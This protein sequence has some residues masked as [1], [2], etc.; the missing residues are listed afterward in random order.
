ML[1]ISVL[2]EN[3]DATRVSDK[4]NE[5]ANSNYSL[6]VS[7]S[8]RDRSTETLILA[9]SFE[10]TSQPPAARFRVSGSATLKGNKEEIKDAITPPE[11]NKPPQ[12]LVVLYERVYST[13]YV[14]S[15]ALRAPHPLPNLLKKSS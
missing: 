6:N 5:N 1:D 12:V 7:L 15:T 3:I 8:E 4:V 2:L 11:D 13:L 10:L 14:L 9:F